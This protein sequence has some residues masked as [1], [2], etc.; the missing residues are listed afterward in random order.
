MAINYSMR[1][2]FWYMNDNHTFV[3][4]TGK[5]V[6]EIKEDLIRIAKDRP[7]GMVCPVTIL[8]GEK[9]IKRIGGCCHADGNG[10]VDIENWFKEIMKE[11]CVRLYAGAVNLK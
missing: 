9:E 5:N 11:E 4:P 7:Y 1:P 3:T 6:Y 10:C 2:S 8:E